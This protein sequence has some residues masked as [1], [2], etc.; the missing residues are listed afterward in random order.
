[1]PIKRHKPEE[2]VAKLRQLDHPSGADQARGRGWH[3]KSPE[4]SALYRVSVRWVFVV[5][6]AS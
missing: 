2:I 5:M 3:G 6:C 4:N 1:M